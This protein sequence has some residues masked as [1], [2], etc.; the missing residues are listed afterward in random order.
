MLAMIIS[1][2]KNLI[3]GLKTTMDVIYGYFKVK[4]RSFMVFLEKKR[5]S[6]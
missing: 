1:D 4:L 2:D 6:S 5:V 3:E